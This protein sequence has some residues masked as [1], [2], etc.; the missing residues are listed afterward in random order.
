MLRNQYH[1]RMTVES[2]RLI[3]E[4]IAYTNLCVNVA[5]TRRI[6]FDLAPEAVASVA[7][8]FYYGLLIQ[9]SLDPSVDTDA[10]VA[11]MKALLGGTFPDGTS[12]M[13]AVTVIVKRA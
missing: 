11:V 5:R 1:E 4:E 8:S 6:N 12:R 3:R 2:H 13:N 9:R 10:Y 7:I